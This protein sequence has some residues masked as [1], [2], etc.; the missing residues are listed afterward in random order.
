MTFVLLGAEPLDV[1][2]EWTRELFGAVPG[3]GGPRPSIRS[4]GFPFPSGGAPLL[5]RIPAVKDI[6]EITVTFTLPAAEARAAMRPCAPVQAF[7]CLGPRPSHELPKTCT[8]AFHA[9]SD[10]HSAP[11]VPTVSNDRLMTGDVR[12]EAGRVRLPPHWPREQRVAPLGAQG[13][14][15]GLGRL[16][17][18]LRGRPR[19]QLRGVALRRRDHADRRR[20]RA[21]GRGGGAALCVR[22]DGEEGR[23]AEVGVG[24]AQRHQGTIPCRSIFSLLS[25]PLLRR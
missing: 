22:R 1:L 5:C 9:G 23:A 11:T 4:S 10:A 13:E 24:G 17:R 2:E 14:G 3:N 15:P 12:D 25:T 6:H 16:R 18:D 20:G 21:V 19:A 8:H 7:L